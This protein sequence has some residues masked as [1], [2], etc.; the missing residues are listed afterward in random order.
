MRRF[1][2]YGGLLILF[3]LLQ[4]LI[5]E[6]I[7]LGPFFY[8]CIYLLFILLFPFGYNTFWLLL[9]SF[10][11]GLSVDLF[12][13]GAIGLH[14]S[15]AT[16]LGFFRSSIL[17]MAATKG[18]VGQFA[19]PG[20]RTLGMT[21]YLVFVVI[22]LLLH[23]AVLFGL[24]NFHFR[25][26]HLTLARVVCSALLNTALIVLVQISLFNRRRGTDK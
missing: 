23:H 24:E 6:R 16:C 3:C 11:M 9:W 22:C 21:W 13:A 17:K 14:A 8:P 20:P 25:Y 5:F 7:Q 26:L 18:D 10:V 2:Q 12:S 15:A 19:V 4:T 1:L